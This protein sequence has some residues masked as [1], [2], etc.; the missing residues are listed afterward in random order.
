MLHR[1]D[2][3]YSNQEHFDDASVKDW[4]EVEFERVLNE[5]F[6]EKER[7]ETRDVLYGMINYLT[8]H[9]GDDLGKSS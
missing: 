9:V 6:E 5:Q 3:L 8:F 4:L 2:D 7:N 1:M